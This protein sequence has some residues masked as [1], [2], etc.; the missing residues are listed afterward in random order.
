MYNWRKCDDNTK[1]EIIKV[2]KQENLPWHS[3]PHF[4]GCGLYHLS[5]S[6]YEHK[7]IIGKDVERL[8]NFSELLLDFLPSLATLKAWCVLPNHYHLLVEVEELKNVIRELGKLHG[9]TSF[10]W[11]K[12]DNSQ[13]RKCWYRIADR[14]IRN[15]DHYYATLNYIHNNPVKHE[16]VK[17]WNEWNY[18]SAKQFLDEVGRD[19]AL[20]IWRQYPLF[21]YGK[22]WDD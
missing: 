10:N 12:E 18:S 11:N 21:N 2:R 13:G 16:Y 4:D 6:N 14:K 9:K 7:N 5:A 17:N 1:V 15:A 3:P 19:K 22:G 20:K 8:N